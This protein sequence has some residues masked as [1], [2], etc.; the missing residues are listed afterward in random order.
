MRILRVCSIAV[1]SALLFG[2]SAIL[3]AQQP[4]QQQKLS[5]TDLERAHLML[6]H[7]YDDV[8]KNYYDPRYHGVDLDASF[9]Q[10]DAR[11][12]TAQSINESFRVIAAFLT[13]L[14]DSHTFFMP[15]PRTNPSTIGFHAEMV[16]EKCLITRIRL[17][18]DAASRL[19][20]GDQVLALDGFNVRRADFSNMLYFLQ[21]LSPA[22]TKKLAL[23]NPSGEHRDEIVR[24]SFR[25]GK[26]LLDISG[27]GDGGD[28]WQLVREE[29]E[30]EH[31]NRE[32]IFENG[33]ALIWKIPSFFVEQSTVDSIFS[34]ARKHQA[35]ILDLRGNPG[36]SIDTLKVMLGHIFD[37]DVKLADR[38]S[39]KDSKAE[40]VKARGPVFGGKLIVLIDSNSASSAELFARVVQLEHRGTVIGDRSAGAVMEARHYDES[41]GVD[42]KIFYGF[43]ITSANLVMTDG[44]SLEDIGVTPDEMVLPAATDLAEGKDPVLSRA[45][46]LAGTKLD[47]VAAGKLFPFE[48]PSI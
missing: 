38:V 8:K 22:P 18:T 33:A 27:G 47:P 39:R 46:E 48:W 37:H 30:D 9:R 36:G 26:A 28:I 31:N 7:A 11:L 20:V 2:S 6:R 32:R 10:Y 4:Q 29:E 3:L 41:I 17:G 35:L 13:G 42:A 25:R 45:A 23:A 34:K 15:P 14:H 1:L 16:G 43:S 40:M 44:K 5:S 24:A 12:D 21:V 19:H